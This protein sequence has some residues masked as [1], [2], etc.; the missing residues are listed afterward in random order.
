MGCKYHPY[1]EKSFGQ[2]A[3]FRKLWSKAPKRNLEII[4]QVYFG[5]I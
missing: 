3:D 2:P 4:G 5:V 1:R